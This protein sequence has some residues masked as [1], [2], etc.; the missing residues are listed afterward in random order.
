MIKKTDPDAIRPY[1]EDASGM[2]G[3]RADAV[4]LP[5]D[6][7]EAASLL[8]ECTARGEPLTLSGGGTGLTGARIPFGG[9]VLATDRMGGVR[10]IR[11]LPAGGGVAV[12]GPALSVEDLEPEAASRGLFYPPNPT[13]RKAWIGGTVA[14]NASGSRTF[15]YGPT[16][17]HVRRLRLA[18]A[19]GERLDLPRGRYRTAPDGSFALPTPSGGEI[20]G[21]LPSIRMP[22]VKNASGYHVMPE[23]D[24][25]DLFIGSE[26]TLALV[27]EVELA[28]MRAPEGVLAGILFFPSEEAAWG[29]LREARS[30]SY[31]SRGYGAPVPPDP[32]DAG[33][34]GP[35]GGKGEMD[36]R[37]LEYF[38]AASLD[39]MRPR[40][41]G[42]P[43]AARAA[44]YFEQETTASTEEALLEAWQRISE[45]NGGLLD[46]S[47]F[48]I[49]ERD[50]RAFRD[51]RHAL[52]E[53]I[54][55]WLS[56]H[57]Q[58]KIGSDMAVPEAAFDA[59]MSVYRDALNP[60]GLTWLAFGH[61]G[62]NHLHVDL[63]PRDADEAA[64]GEEVYARLVERIVPLGGTVSAE[65]GLGKIK[66]GQLAAMY[67]ERVFEEM[68]ALKRAFDP[69]LILCRGNMIPEERL[70]PA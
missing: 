25:V 7:V 3:G 58:R 32:D 34:N 28:L 1:T 4:Y 50:R 10:D 30:L 8:A 46:D 38:D 11:V 27:T 19:T 54:N 29:L 37:A 36:A 55:D 45:A 39:F 5:A 41:R 31:R 64:R 70:A 2:K 63:L 57:G 9:S 44:I 68:A 33:P 15:R 69:A 21:R 60:T 23:M 67:G 62:D 51:F 14:T 42:I 43:G 22:R 47:W 17:R 53:G 59:M 61:L 40:Q 12:V 20:R 52:P 65:H 48:G 56:R 13:E 18:L 35:A 16:R 26:G 49:S 66:A 24:L 6:E